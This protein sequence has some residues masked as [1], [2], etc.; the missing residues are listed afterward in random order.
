MAEPRKYYL[1]LDVET[2]NYAD[3]PLV[4]DLGFAVVDRHAR[5]YAQ[6]SLLVSE[7]FSDEEELM[8]TAYYSA[9]LPQYFEGIGR[10]EW[11]VVDFYTARKIICDLLKEWN[12]TA[13]CAYNAHFD[14]SALNN[15]ERW[16][17]KSKYR[18]F[19]PY[20]T[21][22]FDIWHM[23][24]QVICTQ[25]TYIRY[26]LDNGFASASGNIKTNAETVF[27][28]ISGNS[29][30]DEAHTGLADVLIEAKIMAKC[31]DQHKAMDKKINRSCWRIPQKSAREMRAE[32]AEALAEI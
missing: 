6:R 10:G 15:T 2:A 29:E 3:D 30:F 8:D 23:A 24:C 13:V 26:C 25:R 7:I 22:I 31:F 4:Y 27:G 14:Y 17:T 28:Y 5:V 21:E 11:E 19:F 9:K 18:W 12:I 20:G 16:L 1:V 32:L